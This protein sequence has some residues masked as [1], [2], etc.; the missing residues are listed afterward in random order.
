MTR[1]QAHFTDRRVKEPSTC[2][3]SKFAN[4]L[5]K[6]LCSFWGTSVNWIPMFKDEPMALNSARTMS[7]FPSPSA[8]PSLL[9]Y[10]PFTSRNDET[11]RQAARESVVRMVDLRQLLSLWS[12][13]QPF[14]IGFPSCNYPW[15]FG[16]LKSLML[17]CIIAVRLKFCRTGSVCTRRQTW[18]EIDLKWRTEC[19]FNKAG[20]VRICVMQISSGEIRK[21][22]TWF[23]GFAVI[24]GNYEEL[25]STS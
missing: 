19:E 5:N 18:N 6:Q 25:F 15:I 9:H 21:I 8:S 13:E 12:D 2:R 11:T 23:L 3:K 10:M 16:F 7:T 17:H 14:R 4:R 22:C 1:W 24:C 20:L